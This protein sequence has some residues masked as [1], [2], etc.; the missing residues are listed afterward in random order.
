MRRM[1]TLCLAVGPYRHDLAGQGEP[2]SRTL[3][4]L[5]PRLAPGLAPGTDDYIAKRVVRGGVEPP[6][7]RFSGEVQSSPDVAYCSLTGY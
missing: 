7:F 5:P 2:S 4:D 3:D 1:D 6:T